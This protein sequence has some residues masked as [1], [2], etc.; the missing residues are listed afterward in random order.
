MPRDQCTRR[1][2]KEVKQRWSLDGRPKI[3]YLEF[4]RDSECTFSRCS[5]P[6]LHSLAPTNPHWVQVVGSGLFNQVFSH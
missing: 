3:Y 2:I 1:A 6:H 5:W 4:L